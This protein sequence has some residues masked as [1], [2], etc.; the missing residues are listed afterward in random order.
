MDIIAIRD[1]DALVVSFSS[2]PIVCLCKACRRSLCK[3]GD[4]LVG[5]DSISADFHTQLEQSIPPA[6]IIGIP[7]LSGRIRLNT[8]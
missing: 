6:G 7:I 4:Y 1:A 2:F 8:I 3:M 5:I